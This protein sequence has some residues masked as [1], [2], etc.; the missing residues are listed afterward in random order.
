MGGGVGH[1][2]AAAG[3]AEPASLA[4]EGDEAI[5]AAGVAVNAQESMGEDAALEESAELPFDEV[6]QGT[7][8][9][10][11]QEGLEFGLDDAIEDGLLRPVAFVAGARGVVAGDRRET[12]HAAR[13]MRC[14]CPG[15]GGTSSLVL[16]SVRGDAS[17]RPQG[18]G[19]GWRRSRPRG[20]RTRTASRRRTRWDE[21]VTPADTEMRRGAARPW[22]RRG[23]VS[24][25]AR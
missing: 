18:V 4:R 2:A 21:A 6:R 7:V 3:G 25:R 17:D 14:R 20:I 10:A 9:L 22:R 13:A 16:L 23:G 15:G 19:C 1:A 24:R 8:A 11:G 5:V 12:R